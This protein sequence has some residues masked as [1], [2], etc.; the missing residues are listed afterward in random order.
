MFA[1]EQMAIY[2]RTSMVTTDIPKQKHGN[3][4]L[5]ILFATNNAENETNPTAQLST[6]MPFRATR[7]ADPRTAFH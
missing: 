6:N 2:E 4:Q 7:S 5:R 1:I 3:R